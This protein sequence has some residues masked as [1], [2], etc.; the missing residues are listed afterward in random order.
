MNI[1]VG[2]VYYFHE[3]TLK[4]W[5]VVTKIISSSTVEMT[6]LNGKLKDKTFTEHKYWFK[7]NEKYITWV[8]KQ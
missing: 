8:V 2:D 1:K 3:G 7:S 5:E 4:R 6:V